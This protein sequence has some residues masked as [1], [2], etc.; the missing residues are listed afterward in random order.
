MSL[1][2]WDRKELSIEVWLSPVTLASVA[3]ASRYIHILSNRERRNWQRLRFGPDRHRYLVS[4]VLLRL[5]L[6][7]VV[8]HHVKS[9]LWR[10]TESVNAKP[11]IAASEGL[12]HLNFNLSHA[13]QLAAVAISPSFRLG[14][15]VEPLD[16]SIDTNLGDTVLASAERLWLEGRDHTTRGLDFIQLWTVKEAYAKLLGQGHALDFASF[17]V[18][19]GPTRL[20][21]TQT[22]L[23]QPE[24]VFLNSREVQMSDGAYQLSLAADVSREVVPRVAVHM[25]DAAFVEQ[26]CDARMCVVQP[27]AI[28]ADTD[29]S[30]HNQRRLSW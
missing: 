5:G 11:V 8:D 20:V 7:Q 12:P 1:K 26:Q 25:L 3:V 29:N 22:D 18:A 4:H 24:Q 21:R 14:I 16:Q 13:G 10:F 28:A 27:D 19:L 6:S 30:L 2:Q 17:E 15:D 9:N 23:V